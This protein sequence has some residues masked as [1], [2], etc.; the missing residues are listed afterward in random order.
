MGRNAERRPDKA[1]PPSG[2]RLCLKWGFLINYPD[3]WTQG[4]GTL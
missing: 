2:N 1:E 3:G 4:Q